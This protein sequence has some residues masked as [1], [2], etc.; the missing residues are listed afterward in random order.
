MVPV[1]KEPKTVT[2]P[3]VLHER[4]ARIRDRMSYAAN[5]QLGY[6]EVVE[7]ALDRAQLEEDR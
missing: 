5:R 6:W 1:M 4:L 3:G 2:V 7:R